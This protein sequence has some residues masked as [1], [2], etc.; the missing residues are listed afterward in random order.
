MLTAVS[1]RLPED[2]RTNLQALADRRGTTI[3]TELRRAAAAFT[4]GH[5]QAADASLD[6]VLVALPQLRREIAERH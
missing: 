1:T 3:G 6:A 2:V 5:G 4:K